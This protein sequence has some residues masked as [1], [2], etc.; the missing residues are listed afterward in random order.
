MVRSTFDACDSVRLA[1]SALPLAI[2]LLALAMAS[3]EALMSPTSVDR[4]VRISFSAA[5]RLLL[6]PAS[7]WISIDRSPA[8]TACAIVRA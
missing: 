2:S 8:A 5:S 7:V 1:R 6:S 3:A 4:R